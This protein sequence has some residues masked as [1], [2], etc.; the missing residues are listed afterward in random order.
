M[1]ININRELR[2]YGDRFLVYVCSDITTKLVTA[3]DPNEPTGT[4]SFNILDWEKLPN[5][6]KKA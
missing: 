2:K 5:V 6:N 3:I 4:F 1:N